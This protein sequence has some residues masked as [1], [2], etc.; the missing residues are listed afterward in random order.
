MEQGGKER[1]TLRKGL[2]Y[3]CVCPM[4]CKPRCNPEQEAG[5]GVTVGVKAPLLP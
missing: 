2:I 4:Y 3:V 1:A 5:Q